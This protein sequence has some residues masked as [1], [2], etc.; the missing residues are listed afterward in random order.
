MYNIP[1]DTVLAVLR[2]SPNLQEL[3]VNKSHFELFNTPDNQHYLHKIRTL[4]ISSELFVKH[5]SLFKS[6]ETLIT[7]DGCDE[8]NLS[9]TLICV[10]PTIK[11]LM[12]RKSEGRPYSS[13]YCQT[14][15]FEHL[16]SYMGPDPLYMSHHKLQHL[17]LKVDV[18]MF[19]VRRLKELL[20]E[21]ICLRVLLIESNGNSAYYHE[22][23]AYDIVDVFS[24]FSKS[25]QWKLEYVH[26]SLWFI[27]QKI[28]RQHPLTFFTAMKSSR[29]HENKW[30]D[31]Q[32]KLTRHVTMWAHVSVAIAMH[33]AST[34]HLI[35]LSII[36]HMIVPMAQGCVKLS[37]FKET[38]KLYGIF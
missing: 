3:R 28:W 12:I 30:N 22:N 26:T 36:K 20:E 7:D 15:K 21:C 6:L 11:T 32:K 38:E 29:G 9:T 27:S 19:T 37:P 25:P 33:R 23:S 1:R 10:P 17:N 24:R 14:N 8:F 34:R 18:T 13:L 5:H 2:S 35:D 31:L 4:E 16:E